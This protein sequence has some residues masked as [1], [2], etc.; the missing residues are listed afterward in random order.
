MAANDEPTN[1]PP[2]SEIPGDDP[3]A[4]PFGLWLDGKLKKA[5]GSV[6]EEPIPDEL[7]KLLQQALDP[8]PGS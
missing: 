6:V 5:Y 8:K 4:D 3:S 7:L 1:P 2:V